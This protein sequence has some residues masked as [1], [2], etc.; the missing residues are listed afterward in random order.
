MKRRFRLTPEANA[1]LR[2]TLLD[3]A[4]DNPDTAERLRT[5]G[6]EVL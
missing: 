1:D 5:E 2:E 4:E 6:Y 3:I